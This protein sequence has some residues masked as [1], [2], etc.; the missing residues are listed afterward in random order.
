MWEWSSSESTASQGRQHASH[1][2]CCCKHHLGAGY[3]FGPPASSGQAALPEPSWHLLLEEFLN[4]W[5]GLGLPYDYMVWD[6][7]TIVIWYGLGLPVSR[8]S[9]VHMCDMWPAM[10]CSMVLAEMAHLKVMQQN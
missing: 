9:P 2:C 8:S 6:G 3:V 10:G 1:R 4:M 7:P 5:H